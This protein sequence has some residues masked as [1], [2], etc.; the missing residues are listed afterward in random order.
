MFVS[1]AWIL[2]FLLFHT[3]EVFSPI[4]IQI[5]IRILNMME[6]IIN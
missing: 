1:V 2:N 6:K 4:D 3:I 5:K